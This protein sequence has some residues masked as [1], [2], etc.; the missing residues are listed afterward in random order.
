MNMDV[1][2]E[3]IIVRKVYGKIDS[4]SWVGAVVIQ[5]QWHGIHTERSI[6]EFLARNDKNTLII[7]ASCFTGDPPITLKDD[8]FVIVAC[9]IPGP[10]YKDFWRTNKS[11]QNLQRLTSFAGLRLAQQAGCP[12]AVKMRSDA[13]LAM[14]SCCE[15]LKLIVDQH[16]ILHDPQAEN[17]EQKARILVSDLC[18]LIDD[19]NPTW[20][21]MGH[22]FVADVWS[23]GYV[24]DLM[25]Y[26]DIRDGTLWNRGEGMPTDEH[27]ESNLARQWKSEMCLRGDMQLL[28]MMSRYFVV[29]HHDVALFFWPRWWNYERAIRVG[30]EKYLLSLPWHYPE[31]FTHEQWL[32][33]LASHEHAKL[34]AS[35]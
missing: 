12:V 10:E 23:F 33:E 28:E 17:H 32:Q 24:E 5:G 14:E 15:K 26:F 18:V 34:E 21:H 29:S 8:R 3:D 9:N 27:A 7:F 6:K 35:S 2:F 31:R 19:R 22:F 13:F 4:R 1:N 11:N 20:W 16:P 30:I 25:R